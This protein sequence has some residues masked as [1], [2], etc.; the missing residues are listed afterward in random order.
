MVTPQNKYTLNVPG[1]GT[2]TSGNI[3]SLKVGGH[4]LEQLL[5]SSTSGTYEQTVW[6]DIESPTLY[7][8]ES[9]AKVFN[10][11]HN[12]AQHMYN[13]RNPTTGQLEAT[14]QHNNDQLYLCLTEP[15]ITKHTIHSWCNTSTSGPLWS[16]ANETRNAKQ[17]ERL[18]QIKAL[19]DT[20][21]AHTRGS[22]SN[23]R[24][25]RR[26]GHEKWQTVLR[27]DHDARI[28]R[29]NSINTDIKVAV[30]LPFQT[31]VV[32]VW[33]RSNVVVTLHTQGSW[34]VERTRDA[35]KH[36]HESADRVLQTLVSSWVH[37]SH[38]SLGH[39]H[40]YSDVLAEQTAQAHTK[41]RDINEWATCAHRA[42]TLALH[43][44]RHSH[45]TTHVLRRLHTRR[46]TRAIKQLLAQQHGTVKAYVHVEQRLAHLNHVVFARLR[47][48]LLLAGT[49]IL[50]AMNVCLVAHL[51][52][53]PL[54]LWTNVDNL[55]GISTPGRL[56]G[57]DGRMFYWQFLVFAV[58]TLC[59]CLACKV[60][61]NRHKMHSKK[62]QH[63]S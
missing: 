3:G 45:V 35:L 38:T 61:I 41:S 47:Q 33:T 40:T 6:L 25:A 11:N 12:I 7:D 50:D 17:Q 31:R 9:I 14:C 16:K 55:N 21:R 46:S 63:S 49:S 43:L 8:V 42:H 13:T 54:Q 1:R 28:S 62:T 30:Q 4:S 23:W 19:L 15:V 58:W 53:A 60:H 52:A 22:R 37:N 2:C 57:D 29:R 5:E 34:T 44:L 18:E 32:R 59:V 56:L 27:A 48:Q 36:G 20:S 26:W 24:V 10:I 51:V 39:L